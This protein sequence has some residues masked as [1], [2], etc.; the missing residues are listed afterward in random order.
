MKAITEYLTRNGYTAVDDAYYA[1]IALWQSWYQ[2][3]VNSFHTYTQYNGQRKV[4]R[5]RKTM[6]MAKRFCEDWA[7][8]LLNEKVRINVGNQTAQTAIDEILKNNR[9][10][11]RGN[12]LIEL[13]FALGT[14]AFVEYM[15]NGEVVIDY[16]RGSMVYPLAWDNGII[17]ECAFASERKRGTEKYIYLNIH[18]RDA[19]GRYIIENKMFKR[20]GETIAPADLPEG[21]ADEVATGSELPYYQIIMPNIVN[22]A[23]LS[24]PMG[25]S[26]YA[27]AIDNLQ[28]I[29]LVFDSYD[30][31]FR[32]GKKRILVPLTL[33]QSTMADSGVTRPVFDDNDV[34][35]YVIETGDQNA[36]KIEEMN[37]TLRYD[38]FEA[39]IKTA[40]NLAAYKCGFGENRYRF[41]GGTAMTATQVISQDSDLFRNLKKH[42]LILDAALQGLVKA[43]AQMAG[44]AIGEITI[45][46]DDSII[47]DEDKERQRFMQEIREGLRQPWEYRVKYFGEDEDTA[48][49]MTAVSTIDEGY[50]E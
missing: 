11:V 9:F 37:G 45:E 2:G 41:E 23:D 32:L 4:T 10:S 49:A 15:D 12:Q 34:E 30:N 46:F 20:N 39:G 18:R 35:F 25:I 6:G 24:S 31:E 36:Q 29:D 27:N 7:A 14:G 21:V 8:L 38:A 40:I 22:N 47:E 1:Q 3:K 42:E 19:Q 17:T 26:V 50:S 5:Q 28:N 16:V 13:A 44:I 48:K 43:I 33:T